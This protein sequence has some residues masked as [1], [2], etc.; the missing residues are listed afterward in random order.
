MCHMCDSSRPT[1]EGFS[2]ALIHWFY[3][4][5]ILFFKSLCSRGWG[6]INGV[7]ELSSEPWHHQNYQQMTVQEQPYTYLEHVSKCIK[8]G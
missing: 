7:R 1:H 3:D 6:I 8:F 5:I 2:L 4:I